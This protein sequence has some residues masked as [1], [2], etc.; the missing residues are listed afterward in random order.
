VELADLDLF[1]IRTEAEFYGL[2]PEWRRLHAA[3][4]ADNPFLSWA[5]AAACWQHVCRGRRPFLLAARQNGRLVGVAPLQLERRWGF[6]VVSFLGMKWSEYIGFL[7]DPAAGRVQAALLEGLARHRGEW[8][9]LQLRPL[10]DAYT[11][12]HRVSL[13]G[14][15]RGRLAF[16]DMAPY[17]EFDGDWESLCKSG[18]YWLRE[19]PKSIR[20]FER[21]GGSIECYTGAEAAA[22]MDEV[23]FVEA[24]SWKTT[25]G[26]LSFQDGPGPG[27]MRQAFAALGEKMVLWIARMNG[28]AVAFQIAFP[29]ERKIA[30]YNCGYH[31]EYRKYSPGLIVIYHAVRAAWNG[32]CREY[33]FMH[34]NEA[35]KLER[36]N[37]VRDTQHLVVHPQTLTGWA[38]FL[39]LV[40]PR[41]Y[42][43]HLKNFPPARETY[44]WGRRM[45]TRIRE[46]LHSAGRSQAEARPGA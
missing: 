21:D 44:R 1:L 34:G 5:W 46:L 18:P 12:L 2:E 8:D 14:R 38:A 39:A 30:L 25:G 17:L 41:W 4:G 3:S 31:Q 27:L 15:L 10:T 43:V 32:G 23:A 26:Y 35:Y 19:M 28:T 29:L 40:A 45:K 7:H 24:H 22:Q 9:L 11:D 6:R 13:P 37:A 20:R 16:W 36:T 33:D 42:A